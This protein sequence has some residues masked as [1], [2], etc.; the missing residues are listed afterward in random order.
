MTAPPGLLC[1]DRDA[2]RACAAEVDLCAVVEHVLRR[3]A[4]GRVTLPAESYLPWTNSE[5]AAC[6]CLAMPGAVE[7]DDGPATFGLKLINAATSNPAHGHER[8]TGVAFLFDPETARPRLLAEAGWLSAART[9]AY[10]MVSLT[11]LGPR[12]WDAMT[13][14]G[15]GALARAH[16]EFAARAFPRATHLHLHDLARPRAEALADWT[17]RHHP[18]LTPHVHDDP[19]D[20]VRAATVL[21]LTTT[22]D[23]G[24][25][26]AAWPLP[27]TFIAHVSLDDLLPEVFH[28]AQGLFVDDVG[29]VTDNPRRV[30]G[31]LIR[32]GEI[33]P[34]G[35]LGQVLTGRVPA[36]RPTTGHVVSNPFGMAILDVGLLD[37]LH[38]IARAK[39]HGHEIG[40][41]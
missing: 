11:H 33:T 15:C 35:T 25:L 18:R 34:D 17:H 28:T 40:L 24:Y 9:A 27:G 30:L 22:S 13:L 8:A 6:R 41:L 12:H 14:V 7:N 39:G 5:G 2:I 36:I 37:A 1:L 26:P 32:D 3:H 21:V 29:L 20:A 31:G 4:E 16:I 19:R 38:H 23:R 10:T